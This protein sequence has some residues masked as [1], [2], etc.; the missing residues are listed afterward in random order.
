MLQFNSVYFS[1]VSLGAKKRGL[2][3]FTRT[4]VRLIIHDNWHYS[5]DTYKGTTEVIIFFIS[6]SQCLLHIVD[7]QLTS[8]LFQ[9]RPTIPCAAYN[10][11]KLKSISDIDEYDMMIV[12]WC[13]LRIKDTHT[14][15]SGIVQINWLTFTLIIKIN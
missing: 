11:V 5:D 8:P 7:L 10:I 12:D 3:F 6:E 4:A 9:Y 14:L 13:F 1:S 2:E 15:N